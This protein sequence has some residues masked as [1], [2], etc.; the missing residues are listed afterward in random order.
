[1]TIGGGRTDAGPARRVGESKTGRTLFG[2]QRKRGAQ[3]CLFEI[4]VVIAAR[5][6]LSARSAVPIAFGPSHAC[7]GFLALM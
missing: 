5:T 3:Q 1:M 7:I 6:A 2:N 4:A